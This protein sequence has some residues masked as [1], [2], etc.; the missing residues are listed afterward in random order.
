[1]DQTND[2]LHEAKKLRLPVAALELQHYMKGLPSPSQV[3]EIVS[4]QCD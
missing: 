3:R 1:M 2:I 4:A